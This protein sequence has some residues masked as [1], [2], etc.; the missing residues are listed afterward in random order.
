MKD[1]PQP[2]DNSGAQ[3]CGLAAPGRGPL[4]PP[5]LITVLGEVSMER[6]EL[7]DTSC[8]RP[9]SG[10]LHTLLKMLAEQNH[11]QSESQTVERLKGPGY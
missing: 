1:L 10:Q 8:L 5:L 4:F 6:K 7:H 3:H 9:P 11:S 2:G